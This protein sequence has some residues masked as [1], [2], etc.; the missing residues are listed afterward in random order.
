MFVRSQWSIK[1]QNGS[2]EA[3]EQYRINLTSI[4]PLLEKL[5]ETKDIYWILQGKSIVIISLFIAVS[6]VTVTYV[7]KK[8]CF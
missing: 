4:A 3:L 6:F 1:I 2:M 8:K 5:A 7:I